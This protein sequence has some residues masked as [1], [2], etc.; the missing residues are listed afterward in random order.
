M[1]RAILTEK[2]FSRLREFVKRERG[3]E[4]IFT[5]NDDDLNRKVAEKLPVQIILI[6]LE[7]RRDYTK[8]RDSGLNEVIAKILKKNKIALGFDVKELINSKNKERVLARL[9]QNIEL[10]K[11]L[12]V[13]IKFIYDENKHDL[14]DLKSLGLVLGMP[15]WMAKNL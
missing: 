1:N 13:Q 4:I 6:P 7:G 3:K 10:C 12:K 9:K 5:S 15:T 2:N 14:V 11:R 8:Q